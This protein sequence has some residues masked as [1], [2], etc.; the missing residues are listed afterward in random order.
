MSINVN[1]VIGCTTDLN[2]HVTELYEAMMD[3]EDDEVI[4]TCFKLQ[5]LIK[6]I[7][8]SYVSKENKRPGTSTKQ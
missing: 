5:N 2:D 4:E 6:Y 3:G 7:K 8:S 1:F